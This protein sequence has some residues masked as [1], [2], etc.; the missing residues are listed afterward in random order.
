MQKDLKY[1]SIDFTKSVERER[2]K[3]TD[4]E[5]NPPSLMQPNCLRNHHKGNI[6]IALTVS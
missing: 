1:L 5:Q 6:G 3:E 2:E 4:P